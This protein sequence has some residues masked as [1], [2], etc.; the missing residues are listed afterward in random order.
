MAP[1]TRLDALHPECYCAPMRSTGSTRRQVL[2]AMLLAMVCAA[3]APAARA[4]DSLR[5]DVDRT[6]ARFK[7]TDPGIAKLLGSAAGYAV[8]PRI[9]KGGFIV[10]G[11][12]GRGLVFERGKLVG[13]ARMSQVTVGAQIGGQVYSQLILF[14]N[15]SALARF[16]QSRFEM[17]AQT[18]AVVAAE[19]AARTARYSLGMLVFTLP[20]QGLMAEA[21]IG[22]Q[23]FTFQPI[24]R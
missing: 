24:S 14:E 20:V 8:F 12:G 3:Q 21:S 6:L 17:A 13:S 19:G 22:G 16:K 7:Q 23:K 2:A 10:G 1:P 18:S 9:G 15:A 11:A 4:A 5:K